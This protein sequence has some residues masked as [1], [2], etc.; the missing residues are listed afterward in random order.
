MAL[1]Q[2]DLLPI[3]AAGLPRAFL[4]T[5][6]HGNGNV[7]STISASTFWMTDAY[8]EAFNASVWARYIK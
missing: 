5:S 4:N 8:W 1:F 2:I 3:A 6:I 7:E